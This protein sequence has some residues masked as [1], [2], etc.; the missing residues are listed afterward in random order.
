MRLANLP[1]GTVLLEGL[2]HGDFGRIVEVL[3][4]EARH[5]GCEE[6]RRLQAW[7]VAAGSAPVKVSAIAGDLAA[8]ALS[9]GEVAPRLP[10]PAE[11]D[12]GRVRVL[13]AAGGHETPQRRVD[14]RAVE[15][16]GGLVP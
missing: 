9:R 12:R 1:R 13:N 14:L 15:N 7:L 16:A 6:S 11:Q 4:K 8:L 3:G 5:T 10:L 2:S